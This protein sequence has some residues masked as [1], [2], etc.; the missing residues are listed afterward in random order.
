MSKREANGLQPAGTWQSTASR[1][2]H[3]YRYTTRSDSCACAVCRLHW[4]LADGHW[5]LATDHWPLA[6]NHWPLATGGSEIKP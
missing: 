5:L 6:T 2:D 4:P 1:R 3:C